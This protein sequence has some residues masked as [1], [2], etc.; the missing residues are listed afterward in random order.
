[1]STIY[2]LSSQARARTIGEEGV[3]VLQEDAEVLITNRSGAHLLELC[4]SGATLEELS[5]ALCDTFGA[6]AEQ[7]ERDAR[8]FVDTLQA[9]GAVSESE[10][11]P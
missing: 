9:A 3:V 2:K 1:M 7:A 8:I 11:A 5:A 4:R 6:S 10:G